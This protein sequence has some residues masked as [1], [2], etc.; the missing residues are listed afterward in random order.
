MNAAA[1][2]TIGVLSVCQ[3]WVSCGSGSQILQFKL[4]CSALLL[5]PLLLPAVT[6]E[7]SWHS[8]SHVTRQL[9]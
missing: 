8:G 7:G 3:R 2:F 9:V 5:I 4:V 6:A 1:H